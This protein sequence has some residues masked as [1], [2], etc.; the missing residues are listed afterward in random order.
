MTIKYSIGEKYSNPIKAYLDCLQKER[1]NKLMVEKEII[2]LAKKNSE[3][4]KGIK[5]EYFFKHVIDGKE[6]MVTFKMIELSSAPLYCV[7]YVKV[8]ENIVYQ[9]CRVSGDTYEL[10]S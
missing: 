3:I 9:L 4:L 6:T 7:L 8:D 2:I 5:G 10:Y 1:V